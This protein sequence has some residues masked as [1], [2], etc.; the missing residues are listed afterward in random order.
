MNNPA[1]IKAGVLINGF[2]HLN[3]DDPEDQ[4]VSLIN[5]TK[6][7][8]IDTCLFGGDRTCYTWL[9]FKPDNG[10][11]PY[12]IYYRYVDTLGVKYVEGDNDTDEDG[13]PIDEDGKRV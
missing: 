13:N 6:G 11:K 1:I 3:D 7:S 4:T 5:G 12:W 8:V 10:D 2:Y 9:K